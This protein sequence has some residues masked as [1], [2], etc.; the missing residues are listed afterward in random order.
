MKRKVLIGV[1]ITFG[2]LGCATGGAFAAGVTGVVNAPA[3]SSTAINGVLNDDCSP[4]AGFSHD[5]YTSA[6]A[7]GGGCDITF[8]KG[9]F[10]KALTPVPLLTVLANQTVAEVD[11]T[12]VKNQYTLFYLLSSPAIV[13]FSMQGGT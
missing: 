7:S 6:P 12:L 3:P 2:A 11:V 9:A 5:L 1:A 8:P 10:S 13:T 4:A